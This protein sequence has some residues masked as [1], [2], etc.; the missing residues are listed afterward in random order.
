MLFPVAILAALLALLVLISGAIAA[1]ASSLTVPVPDTFVMNALLHRTAGEYGGAVLIALFAWIAISLKQHGAR[2]LSWLLCLSVAVQGL[3][4]AIPADP[5]SMGLV[6]TLH[7]LLAQLLFAGSAALVVATS[8]S[9]SREPQIIEDYGWPSLRSLS[10][11]LPLLVALQVG[12]GA[13]FRQHVL[14]L[15]PHIVGAMLVS[16]FILMVGAFVLQQCK[17]HPTLQPAGKT[18]MVSTFVQVFLGIAAFT[19]RSLPPDTNVILTVSTAHVA[20]GAFL[21]AAS[22]VLGM[23]IRRNVVPK[24]FLKKD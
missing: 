3:L 21:L 12:L 18:L 22:V 13:A 17:D 10:V 16:L 5:A 15:M 11:T 6:G 20:T 4:G 14:G 23:Q 8:V 2:R 1:T 9:W 24:G 7:A 19:V